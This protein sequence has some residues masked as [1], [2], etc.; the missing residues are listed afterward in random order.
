MDYANGLEL[1]IRGA[2]VELRRPGAVNPL[3]T[4]NTDSNGFYSFF[5]APTGEPLEVVVKAML[6]PSGAET[7]RV[8]DNTKGMKVYEKSSGPVHAGA[9]PM[10]THDI[11]AKTVWNAATRRHGVREAAPFAILDDVYQAQTTV[12]SV[13]PSIVWAPAKFDLSGKR[14]FTGITMAR[15]A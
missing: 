13:D 8:A 2:I 6:G 7:A 9:R 12:R 10:Q 15:E 14:L 4:T 5:G 3:Q 11:L 1:P